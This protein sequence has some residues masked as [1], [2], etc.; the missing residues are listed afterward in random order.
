MPEPRS[1]EQTR[2]H[3]Y[4]AHKARQGEIILKEPWQRV[5]FVAGLAGFFA[6][7]VLIALLRP[8]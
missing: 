7:A 5:V 8:V 4:P 6:L 1:R 3:A 2:R